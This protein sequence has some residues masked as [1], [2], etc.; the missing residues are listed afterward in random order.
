MEAWGHSCGSVSTAKA[1]EPPVG[2]RLVVEH[3]EEE[4]RLP[5]LW[6]QLWIYGY[7]LPPWQLL[8]LP[9]SLYHLSQL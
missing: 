7:A 9:L 5:S 3:G 1:P 4:L 8:S 2:H 6:L